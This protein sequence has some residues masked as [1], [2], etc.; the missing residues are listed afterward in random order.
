MVA[1]SA[2]SVAANELRSL[3][4]DELEDITVSQIRIGYPKETFV[5]MSNT[6]SYLNL[7][8]YNVKYDGYPSDGLS[9]DPFYV[10]IYCLITPISA[11]NG[12]PSSGEND[13]RYIGEIMRILH[14]HPYLSIANSN[15]VEVAQLQII[16]HSLSLDDLNH[17]WS[18]QGDTPYRLSIAYEIALAPI[19]L[20]QAVERSPLV[21]TPFVVT[22]GAIKRAPEQ[23]RDGLINLQPTVDYFEINTDLAQWTPQI[24]VVENINNVP[25]NLHY[26]FNKKDNLDQEFDLLIAGKKGETV[27]IF[28]NIWRIRTDGSVVSWHE[29]IADMVSPEHVIVND[30]APNNPFISNIIEPTNIDPRALVKVKLPTDITVD[31]KTWQAVLYVTRESKFEQPPAS[32]EIIKTEIKSNL[33]LLYG[34]VI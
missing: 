9:G 19:L 18:T 23:E 1:I 34:G 7:F 11:K 29:N 33:V 3:L 24:A 4:A 6:T 13:L 14:E 22:W 20:A 15:N 5:N 16:P 31:T 17:V 27:K 2:L 30:Q 12:T 32:G 8:F 28:W 26:V 25:E 10:R 21:S